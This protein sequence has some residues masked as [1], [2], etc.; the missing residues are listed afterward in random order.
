MPVG[1]PES[2]AGA[3]FWT[4]AVAV[5][6]VPVAITDPKR[7]LREALTRGWDMV[8]WWMLI[9]DKND[10]NDRSQERSVPQ[11]PRSGKGKSNG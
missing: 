11:S 5:G 9:T 7:P 8:E 2:G 4:R 6:E 10:W 3:V 1:E